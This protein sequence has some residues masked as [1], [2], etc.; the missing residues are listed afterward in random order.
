MVL[1]FASMLVQPASPTAQALSVE[2][3]TSVNRT[4]ASM[5]S[6]AASSCRTEAMNRSISETIGSGS[7][8]QMTAD[9]LA[10]RITVAAGNQ[11]GLGGRQQLASSGSS[12]V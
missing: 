11:T 4:V 6:R 1:C 3:T 12:C 7:C 8:T 9:R 10:T 2:P 5:R